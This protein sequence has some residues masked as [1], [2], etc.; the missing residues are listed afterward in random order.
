MVLAVCVTAILIAAVFPLRTYLSQ[1]SQIADLARQT[2]VLEDR[3]AR[4]DRRIKQLHDPRYLEQLA[5]QCLGM[6]TPG[7]VAFVIV[8]KHGAPKPLAC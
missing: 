5:R 7:E 6:V 4:L 1:R 2:A 3:N 8:P